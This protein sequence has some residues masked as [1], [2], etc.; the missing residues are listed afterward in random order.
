MLFLLIFFREE[1]SQQLA[2]VSSLI[3]RNEWEEIEAIC[4]SPVEFSTL[5]TEE[6]FYQKRPLLFRNLNLLVA[7][8]NRVQF[9]AESSF[10]CSTFVEDFFNFI[11]HTFPVILQLVRTLHSLVTD[12]N[13]AFLEDMNQGERNALLGFVDHSNSNEDSSRAPK[14]FKEKL[15]VSFREPGFTRSQICNFC[16]PF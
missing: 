5:F 3:I 4:R 2:F 12:P 16:F 10:G 11:R 6:T 15:H 9:P 14:S 8:F 7:I 1:K 13:L